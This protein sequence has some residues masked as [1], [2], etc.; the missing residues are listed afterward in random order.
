M[1]KA[2]L[3]QKWAEQTKKMSTYNEKSIALK[4]FM[5]PGAEKKFD[6]LSKK[7]EACSQD[8]MG[9]EDSGLISQQK[10]PQAGPFFM[11]DAYLISGS[12]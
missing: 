5:T 9:Q 6:D 12:L 10:G 8:V 7:A 1:Q 4:A 3:I 11:L 2:S